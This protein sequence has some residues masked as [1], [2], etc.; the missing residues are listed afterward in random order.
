MKTT[1]TMKWWNTLD[2]SWQNI[3][4]KCLEMQE[5]ETIN[6]EKFSATFPN[7]TKKVP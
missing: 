1:F 6:I 3:F 2:K 4:K 7:I 5:N